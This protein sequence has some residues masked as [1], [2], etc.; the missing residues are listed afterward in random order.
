MDS[1]MA[2]IVLQAK[3]IYMTMK[4]YVPRIHSTT[5][6]NYILDNFMSLVLMKIMRGLCIELIDGEYCL[7]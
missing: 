4:T 3:V 1:Q 5:T 7:C 2:N 6:S